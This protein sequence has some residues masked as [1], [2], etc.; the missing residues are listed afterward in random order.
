MKIDFHCHI[1]RGTDSY[2]QVQNQ[3]KQF[4]GYGF[5]ERIKKGVKNVQS[6]DTEDIFEKTLY[7][8]K[9]A[10]LKKV[11]LLPLSMKENEKVFDW[12]RRK[13]DVF[14]PFFNLPEKPIKNI[15]IKTIMKEA[16]EEHQIKGLKIMNPFREKYLNDPILTEAFE[17]AQEYQLIVLMHTGYPPPGT[18]RNV[19][20]Y[21]NP[22]KI[23]DIIQNFPELKIIIAHMGYPW[24]DLALSLAVQYPNIYMDISN[25][26]YMM[27]NRLKEF[28]LHAKELI[29]TDKIL[30]GSDGFVPEMIEMTVK[31]FENINYLQKRE[32][33][34][35]MGL[36]ARR[37]LQL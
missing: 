28:I 4:T 8:I 32:I 30:F 33:E 36:N 17:L 27:P 25:L 19:L 11:V 20:T 22:L 2:S 21:A 3:F 16:I 37:L 6:I 13:P 24:V 35:I 23:E 5:Y 10:D 29:G 26:T 31:Y 18:M 14:I 1:F 9:K 12:C 15:D 7:H 34:K